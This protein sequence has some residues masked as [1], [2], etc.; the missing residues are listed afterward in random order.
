MVQVLFVRKKQSGA[1]RLWFLEYSKRTRSQASLKKKT[2]TVPSNQTPCIVLA[3]SANLVMNSQAL[4]PPHVW[5]LNRWSTT[6]TR[7]ILNSQYDTNTSSVD[8]NYYASSW[9]PGHLSE[10]HYE[11]KMRR[12]SPR[13]H[14]YVGVFLQRWFSSL[15]VREQVAQQT[16]SGVRVSLFARE[17]DVKITQAE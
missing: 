9:V 13:R 3:S 16:F 14:D 7:Q 10:G 1:R 5:S 12:F 11:G 6:A 2:W 4:F 15:H 8:K 17:V